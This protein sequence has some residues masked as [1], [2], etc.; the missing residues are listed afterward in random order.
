LDSEGNL[1]WNSPAGN[2]IIVRIG[3][4]STGQTN[5]TGGAAKGLECDK[6]NAAAI[7]L[8]FENWFGKFYTE[9]DAALAKQVIKVFSCG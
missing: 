7:K 9:T 2:W 5:A 3:H 6:F 8:Q 1:N 4:T